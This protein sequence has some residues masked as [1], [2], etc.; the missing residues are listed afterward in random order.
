VPQSGY[1]YLRPVLEAKSWVER[2]F[3]ELVSRPCNLLNSMVSNKVIDNRRDAIIE[4]IEHDWKSFLIISKHSTT[5]PIWFSATHPYT[6]Q[7]LG[8]IRF[9]KPEEMLELTNYNA[10]L[11]PETMGLGCTSK[12]DKDYL[13]GNHGEGYKLAALALLRDGYKV[14][15]KTS[16]HT[17]T[18][19]ED[20]RASVKYAK[21]LSVE[22][23]KTDKKSARPTTGNIREDVTF[24]ISSGRL[25]LTAEEVQNWMKLSLQ[26]NPPK[27]VIETEMGSLILDPN[28][29]NKIF[30]K[31]ILYEDARVTKTDFLFGYNF[32]QGQVNRDRQRLSNAHEQ[33]KLLADIWAKAIHQCPS[34][35]G[36]YINMLQA[37][38]PLPA[39]LE[40]AERYIVENT[41]Q[42][43]WQF[44]LNKD[45]NQKLFYY[46]IKGGKQVHSFAKHSL[47]ILLTNCTS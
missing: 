20:D 37:H 8:Y 23:K 9:S 32:S 1:R 33:G 18:F 45:P 21:K 24:K 39:D 12:C 22:I 4:S 6:N 38:D 7:E 30:L 2:T 43:I 25:I 42:K 46:N 47:V 29:S 41:V 19:Y 44:L 3:P 28:F 36:Q 34:L 5:F 17:W 27:E 26:L 13:A 31:G 15:V 16:K 35:V 40:L 10:S 11:H 14:N